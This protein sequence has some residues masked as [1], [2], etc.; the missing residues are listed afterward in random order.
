M[1]LINRKYCWKRQK[2]TAEGKDSKVQVGVRGQIWDCANS[3]C[4]RISSVELLSLQ[5]TKSDSQETCIQTRSPETLEEGFCITA[6]NEQSQVGYFK[7]LWHHNEN[8]AHYVPECCRTIRRIVIITKQNY[9]STKSLCAV[10]AMSLNARGIKE[11]SIS[12]PYKGN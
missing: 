1:T 8:M 2:Q 4:L 9:N 10:R 12:H 3:C 7:A 6:K 11:R 5:C